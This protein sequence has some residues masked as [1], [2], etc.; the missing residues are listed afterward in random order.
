MTEQQLEKVILEKLAKGLL[1]GV[2]GNDW[3][4][5]GYAKVTFRKIIKDG[6]PQILRFSP[7][8]KYF[9]NKETVK[10][11]GKVTAEVFETVAQKLFFFKKYGW[12]M[13][14][15]DVRAY[16]ALFKGKV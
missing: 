7:D 15:P 8:G 9:D 13:D 2:V 10:F 12:L 3:E 4:T 16:S 11:A 6:L 14:D 1:D 5:G